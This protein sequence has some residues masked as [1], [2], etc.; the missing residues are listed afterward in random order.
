MPSNFSHDQYK[1]LNKQITPPTPTFEKLQHTPASSTSSGNAP[2]SNPKYNLPN[3]NKTSS[4]FKK[5]SPSSI[6]RG[7]GNIPFE[8]ASFERKRGAGIVA[9]VLGT[10]IVG[11]Y[12]YTI[13]S[14][15]QENFS[16]V[17]IPDTL[18]QKE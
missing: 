16:D 17:V 1:N 12:G 4:G 5:V 2:S 6:F 10:L 9:L 15:K 3:A 11:T 7:I 14:M 18:K 8:A 13:Y